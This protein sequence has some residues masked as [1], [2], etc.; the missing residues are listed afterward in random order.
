[1]NIVSVKHI[2]IKTNSTDTHTLT[3][4]C[5]YIHIYNI[6]TYM[7]IST[8]EYSYKHAYINLCQDFNFCVYLE[9]LGKVFSFTSVNSIAMTCRRYCSCILGQFPASLSFSF[10]SIFLHLPYHTVSLKHFT[11]NNA[12]T[13]RVKEFI[14]HSLFLLTDCGDNG[15]HT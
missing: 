13:L 14:I 10:H 5:I 4:I 12:V 6:Y 3:Y 11:M 2:S 1:M 8:C 15:G 7:Q 9:T